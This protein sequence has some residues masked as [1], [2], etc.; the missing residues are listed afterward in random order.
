MR[1]LTYQ[2]LHLLG[3]MMLIILETNQI[4]LASNRFTFS[5]DG[6]RMFIADIDA[7]GGVDQTNS[8]N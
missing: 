7:D 6:M 8:I 4:G 3:T 5:N 1:N 2:Q